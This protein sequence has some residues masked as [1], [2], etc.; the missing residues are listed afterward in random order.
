MTS[1]TMLRRSLA[2]V[3]PLG[4]T[5]TVAALALAGCSSSSSSTPT[6]AAPAT[7]APTSVPSSS[8]SAAAPGSTAQNLPVTDAVRSELVAAR[9]ASLGIAPSSYTGLTPGD[10]YYAYDPSTG[11]YWAAAQVQPQV[12]STP[13]APG[14]DIYK[15]QVSSQDDGSYVLFMKTS[16]G[17]WTATNDGT[18]G[19]PPVPCP[20]AVPAAVAQVWGWP[21][22]ACRPARY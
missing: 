18:S 6:S 10:T 14:T 21:S 3:V 13:A 19:P 5:L 9:A 20:V 8:T 22:G 17:T 7:T 16:G 4:A 12:P 2:R 15:A 1:P 11:T